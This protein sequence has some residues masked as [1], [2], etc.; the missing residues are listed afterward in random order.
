[1]EGKPKFSVVMPAY[2]CDQFITDSV[3]SVLDQ[4]Y[5]NFELIL[6]DDASTDKTGTVMLSWASRGLHRVKYI[7]RSANGGPTASLITGQSFATGEIIVVVDG[8][9]DVIERDTLSLYAEKYQDP[10][11]WVCGAM[12]DITMHGQRV[13]SSQ[14]IFNRQ[15]DR[16]GGVQ[17]FQPR[18]WRR[19]LWDKIPCDALQN[20]KT[21]DWWRS[22]SDAS[23]LWP[24]WEL[25]GA[26][27]VAYVWK[28]LYVHNHDNPLNMFNDENLKIERDGFFDYIRSL[29]PYMRLESENS[30]PETLPV[31]TSFNW[32]H[33]HGFTVELDI[34]E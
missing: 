27:R 33:E 25:A 14:F 19:W 18:S 17:Q 29:R 22:C 31:E 9:G 1:M 23:Y 6:V 4:T 11:T 15:C 30:E 10:N 13:P 28:P 8:D 21:G 2:N 16:Y 24:M 32:Q 12:L 3:K 20:P 26:D 7:Y 5:E 34:K